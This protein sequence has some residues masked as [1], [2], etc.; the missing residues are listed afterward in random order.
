MGLFSGFKK[1]KNDKDDLTERGN[2]AENFEDPGFQAIL[3]QFA[4]AYP[5]QEG[6]FF[7]TMVSYRLGGKDPLDYVVVFKSEEGIP[8]WHYV[9]CGF[10]DLYAKEGKNPELS[11][12]GFELTFRL[13]RKEEKPPVWPM[14]F[15]Q[16]LARYVFQTGNVFE[17]NQHM[18]INGPIALE[19]ETKL[20]A[21]GFD[22]DPLFG[23]INTPNGRV[24]FIQVIALTMDEMDSMMLWEGAKFLSL[25]RR[26][27]PLGIAVLSRD[28][29]LDKEEFK[30]ELDEGIER[31]GSS[32]GVFYVSG[33]SFEV[34]E[35]NG[36][37]L[38]ILT[39]G[40]GSVSKITAIVKARL[41]K[42]RKLYL[43]EEKLAIAFVMA[44][45]C[46][47]GKES[48]D[49]GVIQ[50][51]EKA[52]EEFAAIEPHV[53]KYPLRSMPL[54]IRVEKTEIRDSQGNIV[55]VVE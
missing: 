44:E 18:D 45:K 7:G 29:L 33:V 4:K 17:P 19:K 9:T 48:D 55:A 3:A 25:Y 8:N 32:T 14:N 31:D 13:E 54:F 35:Y 53:G 39:M 34:G 5:N 40:A 38:A 15:L 10:S 6:E 50:L 42:G 27:D 1:K 46:G 37:K 43:Q 23:S 52:L 30:K 26:Y 2:T 28:S 41:S 36:M 21:L 49:F 24:D 16:N 12:F 11:G 22:R 20:A 51:N 47:F